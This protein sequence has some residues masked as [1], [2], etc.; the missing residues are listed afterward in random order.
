MYE[1]QGQHAQTQGI[2]WVNSKQGHPVVGKRL[3]KMCAEHLK[4]TPTKKGGADVTLPLYDLLLL[5]LSQD[6]KQLHFFF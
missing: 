3:V 5:R 6:K 1:V 4:S 2:P